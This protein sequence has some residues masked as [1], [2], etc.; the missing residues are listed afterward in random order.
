MNR[1][2]TFAAALV[3]AVLAGAISFYQM[4]VVRSWAATL[5]RALIGVEDSRYGYGTW[6][7]AT[8]TGGTVAMHK[9][10]PINVL[11]RGVVAD[12]STDDADSLQAVIDEVEAAGEERDAQEAH[13]HRH[14]V[15]EQHR[16]LAHRP[17]QRVLVVAGVAAHDHRD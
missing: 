17:D 2:A 15:R 5:T 14:L 8:S 9:I 4:P 7:R 3:S 16:R 12:G 10:S 11:A 6:N 1:R 13:Q